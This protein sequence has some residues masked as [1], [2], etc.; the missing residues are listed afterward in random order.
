MRRRVGCQIV[1][2]I[3]TGIAMGRLLPEEPLPSVRQLALELT[4][5]PNTVARAYLELEYDGIIYK[6]QGHGT[7][8]SSQGVEMSKNERR[9]VLSE[10][11]EKA[12]VEGVNLGLKESELRETFERVIERIIQSREAE[13]V[14]K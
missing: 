13:P 6:R 14:G 7:F 10:L 1:N 4:V 11:I 3:K 5:N 12:L 9:K 8:V 2:Q